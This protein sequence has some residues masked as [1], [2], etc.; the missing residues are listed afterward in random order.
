MCSSKVAIPNNNMVFGTESLRWVQSY[1]YLGVLINSNGE[2]MS[3]SENLWVCGWKAFFKIKSVFKNIDT[4]YELK[5]KMLNVLVKTVVCYNEEIWGV[6]NY[7]FNSKSI[8][9][10]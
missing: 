7:V 9:Q 10:F 5:L 6:L 8:N 4:D 3:S 2:C 1:K